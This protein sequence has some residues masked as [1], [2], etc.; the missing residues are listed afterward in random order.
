MTSQPNN[1][2]DTMCRFRYHGGLADASRECVSGP[3]GFVVVTGRQRH[4]V[5]YRDVSRVVRTYH[6]RQRVVGSQANPNMYRIITVTG[7]VWEF[8]V[9]YGEENAYWRAV[10]VVQRRI[11]GGNRLTV[12]LTSRVQA[13][14]M[15]SGKARDAQFERDKPKP[16][17]SLIAAIDELRRCG[18][19]LE[20]QTN[21]DPNPRRYRA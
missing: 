16:E 3:T 21:A 20:D 18:L 7:Q 17:F 12:G 11:Y 10:G 2:G 6:Q 19:V 14:A 13:E 1:M 8:A 15:K 9:A 4:A 5:G